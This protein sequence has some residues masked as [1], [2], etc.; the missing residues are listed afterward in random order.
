MYKEKFPSF[1]TVGKLS[2][3][4]ISYLGKTSVTTN[5]LIA[6]ILTVSV[7]VTDP[8]QGNTGACNGQL[9]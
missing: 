2:L 6:A 7:A 1:K 8:A 4:S 3:C 5:F 9:V